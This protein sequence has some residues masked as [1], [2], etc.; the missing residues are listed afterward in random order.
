MYVLVPR[1]IVRGLQLQPEAR[2]GTE[3]GVPARNVRKRKPRHCGCIAG[4]VVRGPRSSD[5]SLTP[6]DLFEQ[7]L[8][9]H[10]GRI[11]GPEAAG[12]CE[13][14]SRAIVV[15]VDAGGADQVKADHRAG[16]GVVEVACLL[17]GPA[18]ALPIQARGPVRA[19]GDKT[20]C[21]GPKEEGVATL[22]LSL[23]RWN[24]IAVA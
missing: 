12:F 1:Q 2:I 23:T 11:V 9:G 24:T 19:T 8:C 3:N 17:V 5:A 16:P 10:A 22:P 14:L 4:R 6:V 18:I 21:T 20:Q 13:R 7:C 15:A